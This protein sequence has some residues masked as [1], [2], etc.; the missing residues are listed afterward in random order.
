MHNNQILVSVFIYDFYTI[1]SIYYINLKMEV[2]ALK[3]ET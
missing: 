1:L 3:T 2:K